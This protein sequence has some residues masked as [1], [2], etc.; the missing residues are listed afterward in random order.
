MRLEKMLP[1]SIYTNKKYILVLLIWPT[2]R[3]RGYLRVNIVSSINA[4]KNS[5]VNIVTSINTDK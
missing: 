3:G 2:G 4:D 5:C 1:T